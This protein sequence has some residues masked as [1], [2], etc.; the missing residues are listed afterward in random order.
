MNKDCPLRDKERLNIILH[1]NARGNC[2]GVYDLIEYGYG[3]SQLK[4]PC[5]KCS[6]HFEWEKGYSGY[7]KKP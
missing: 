7:S 2:L 5:Q 6:Y 1:G 4:I 3:G